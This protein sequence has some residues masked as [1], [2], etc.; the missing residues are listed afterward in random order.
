MARLSVQFVLLSTITLLFVSCN[1]NN[2]GVGG[3]DDR[4][5]LIFAAASLA[6]VLAQAVEIYEADTGK[7]VDFSFG[8]SITLA[9]QIASFGAPADGVFFVGKEPARVIGD[10]GLIADPGYPNLYSNSLVVIGS[11]DETPLHSLGELVS[12]QAR[13]AVGDPQLAPAGVYARQALESAGIW[14]EV[15]D[16]AIFTLDVRAAM[17]AVES[18]NARYGIVYKTD[19]VSSDAVSVVYEITGAGQ[20]ITYMAIPLNGARSADLAKEFLEF[21]ALEPKTRDLFISAGFTIVGI[22]GQP[23]PNTR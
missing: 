1:G 2:D 12:Q 15:S 13:I 4:V 22:P 10:A 16:L 6:D 21:I 14:E 7:R 23:G 9:N 17:A 5:P 19:A 20:E 18:G 11:I 8:G 3:P